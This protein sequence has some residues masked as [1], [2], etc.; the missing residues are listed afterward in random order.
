MVVWM[1][2]LLVEWMVVTKV[3]E[4]VEWLVAQMDYY[5]VEL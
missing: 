1:A 5:L 4:R 2:G 3:G